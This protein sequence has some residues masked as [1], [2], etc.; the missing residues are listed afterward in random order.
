MSTPAERKNHQVREQLELGQYK[1]AL[2]LCNKRIKKGEKSEYLLVGLR[3]KLS[4]RSWLI[5]M[6]WRGRP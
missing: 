3:S 6:G 1:Q 2:Q 5:D 4:L